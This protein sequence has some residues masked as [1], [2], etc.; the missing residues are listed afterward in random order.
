MK[1]FF[2]KRERYNRILNMDKSNLI[3]IKLKMR[4]FLI[5]MSIYGQNLFIS[6]CKNIIV[7]TLVQTF[8]QLIEGSLEKDQ[9]K[10]PIFKSSF[11]TPS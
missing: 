11:T 3:I 8:M 7:T 2:F 9:A 1:A 10:K 5:R 4:R 6:N